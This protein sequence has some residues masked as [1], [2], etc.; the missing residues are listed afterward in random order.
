[1]NKKN[2]IYVLL[3]LVLGLWGYIAFRIFIQINPNTEVESKRFSVSESINEEQK[4]DFKLINDYPDPFLKH[5]LAHQTDQNIKK[6][7]PEQSYQKNLTYWNWPNMSYG[8]CIRN[9]KRTVGLLQI[10]SKH[11][12][13]QKGKVYEEFLIDQLYAD[14]IVVKRESQKRTILKIK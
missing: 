6:E 1:M 10:N 11:L 7:E 12:L 9:K 13:V 5:I 4:L 2:N 8:G 14:S 3:P